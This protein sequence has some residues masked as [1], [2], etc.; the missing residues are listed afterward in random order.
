MKNNV[1]KFGLISGA[2]IAAFVVFTM[3]VW[4]CEA[5]SASMVI[6]FAAQILALSFMFV[7]IK[8]YRDNQNG[9]VISFGKAFTIGLYVSLIA[10]TLYVAAWVIDYY[11]FMHDIWDNALAHLQ[12]KGL[13]AAELKAKTAEFTQIKEIYKN[14]LMIIIY[15]YLEIL[16]TGLV[17]SLVAALIMKRK[18]GGGAKVVAAA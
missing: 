11:C 3:N 1:L 12:T 16:P 18:A 17:V 7:A 4:G 10:S 8:N 15:T 13:P 5:S 2:L 9:G 14:P 6:G